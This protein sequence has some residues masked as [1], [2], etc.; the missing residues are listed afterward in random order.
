MKPPKSDEKTQAKPDVP[1]AILVVFLAM[2][3]PA[4][5]VVTQWRKLIAPHFPRATP[6]LR[7]RAD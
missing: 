4:F 7:F 5:A 6:S 3:T 2:A 1:R